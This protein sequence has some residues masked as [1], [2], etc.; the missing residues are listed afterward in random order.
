MENTMPQQISS[1]T[2]MARDTGAALAAASRD[3]G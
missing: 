3:A 2:A 1:Q